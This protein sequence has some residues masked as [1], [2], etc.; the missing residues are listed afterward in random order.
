MIVLANRIDQKTF[1]FRFFPDNSMP[2]L[3]KL[4]AI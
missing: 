2:A 4:S 3:R 1:I